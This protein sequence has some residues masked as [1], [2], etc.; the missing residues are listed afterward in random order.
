MYSPY[1]RP[2][3]LLKF[4]NLIL[5][6]TSFI[7][8]IITFSRFGVNI[9][10]YCKSPQ[11]VFVPNEQYK[12]AEIAS[13]LTF[14]RSKKRHDKLLPISCISGLFISNNFNTFFINI[15]TAMKY[16][17]WRNIIIPSFPSFPKKW[18]QARIF[19]P[20]SQFEPFLDMLNLSIF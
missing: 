16:K 9:I 1:I 11:N 5:T 13:N 7:W 15:V 2:K 8:I 3:S 20:M 14:N 19:H 12:A 17:F 10:F 18:F 6:K 4:L